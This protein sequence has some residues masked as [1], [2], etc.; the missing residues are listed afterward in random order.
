MA[1]AEIHFGLKPIGYFLCLSVLKDG[2]IQ[3]AKNNN[4]L[5]GA[6]HRNLCSCYAAK[7]FTG[8]AHRNLRL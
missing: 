7:S 5:N 3:K 4:Y 6:A 8:A 1:K 2:A